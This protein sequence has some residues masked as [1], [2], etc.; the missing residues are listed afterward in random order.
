[1]E[2]S[3]V[4]DDAARLVQALLHVAHKVQVGQKK[5]QRT[6]RI[7]D[8]PP[9]F[10]S[11]PSSKHISNIVAA[12]D[13][14]QFALPELN[15]PT[16]DDNLAVWSLADTGSAVHVA[17]PSKHFCERE[18]EREREQ[19]W[20]TLA[21]FEGQ[22]K[23]GCN[24]FISKEACGEADSA[25]G[26]SS[27]EPT[28][29]IIDKLTMVCATLENIADRRESSTTPQGSRSRGAREQRRQSH[30]HSRTPSRPR[31]DPQFKGCWHCGA[32]DHSR[33]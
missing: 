30:A 7:K 29:P 25:K 18:R 9:L 12:V 2:D 28:D 23:Q 11:K 8:A 14:E 33:T 22:M 26:S 6:Q 4:E 15:L 13:K 31:P 24:S 32:T 19:N 10:N 3:G 16:D 17:D 21:R 5:P 1:M 20:P 27:P